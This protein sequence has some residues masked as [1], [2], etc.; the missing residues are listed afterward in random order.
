M[1]PKARFA[2]LASITTQEKEWLEKA[3]EEEEVFSAIN[4]CA[5]DKSPGLDGYTKAFYQS[6]WNFTTLDIMEALNHFHQHCYM[7]RSSN[8]SFIALVPKKKGAI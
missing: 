7:V 6:T 8:A 1:R 2:N 5:T 3:F 4:S